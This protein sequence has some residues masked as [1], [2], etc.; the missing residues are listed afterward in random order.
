MCNSENIVAV[1]VIVRQ[2]EQI[3]QQQ[4][5]IKSLKKRLKNCVC[6]HCGFGFEQA[7]KEK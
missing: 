3:K 4:A 5:E 7:L 1:D 6:P 2:Q